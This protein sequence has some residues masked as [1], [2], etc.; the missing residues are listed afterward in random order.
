[1]HCIMHVQCIVYLRPFV[2]RRLL[3]QLLLLPAART[4]A[5][6]AEKIGDE[7]ARAVHRALYVVERGGDL[8]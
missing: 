6:H 1:M 5:A 3:R 8:L 4:R 2:Q 7:A